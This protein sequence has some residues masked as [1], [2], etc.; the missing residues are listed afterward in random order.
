[1]TEQKVYL[2]PENLDQLS[3]LGMGFV[4]V[5]TFFNTFALSLVDKVTSGTQRFVSVTGNFFA[6]VAEKNNTL[7]LVKMRLMLK[8]V[9]RISRNLQKLLKYFD[10]TSILTS[11]LLLPT[12]V[13]PIIFTLDLN[14]LL[15]PEKM[16]VII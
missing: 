5:L 10:S 14:K 9:K 13:F 11:F 7:D 3:N 6:Q 1:M 16:T 12:G 15:L 8:L 2:L 4:I